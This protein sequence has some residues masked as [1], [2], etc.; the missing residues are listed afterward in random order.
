MTKTD[1][2]KV[3][4]SDL[5]KQREELDKKENRLEK[6][7]EELREKLQKVSQ[8]TVS[9]AEKL[10]LK[11]IEIRIPIYQSLYDLNK[12]TLCYKCKP[13]PCMHRHPPQKI[14]RLYLQPVLSFHHYGSI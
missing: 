3:L 4:I 9:E 1:D 10:L 7:E 5:R 8:M 11:E 14:Q 2:I 12:S 6:Q 13:L